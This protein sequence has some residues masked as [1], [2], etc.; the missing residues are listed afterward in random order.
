MGQARPAGPDPRQHLSCRHLRHLRD[1]DHRRRGPCPDRRRDRGRRGAGRQQ[2]PAARLQAE[3]RPN[4]LHSHEHF[5][6]VGGISALQQRT[7]ANCSLRPRA[8]QVFTTGK[9]GKDDPQAGMHAPFPTA[10]S[11]DIADRGQRVRLGGLML[12]VDR[13]PWPYARRDELSLG[14]LRRRR[15]PDDRLCRQPDPGQPRRLSLQRPPGISRRPIA[16]RSP[17]S[18]RARARSCFRRTPRRASSATASRAASGCSIRMA[19]RPMPRT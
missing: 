3:R 13:D 15:V 6:H 10:S 14:Q 8:A 2:Y 1:P 12:D 9:P 11:T 7:G 4:L 19:A 5:D 16:P 17:R 18:P